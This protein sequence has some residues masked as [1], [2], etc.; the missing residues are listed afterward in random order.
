MSATLRQLSYFVA[1]AEERHFGRAAD[2]VHVTQPA[3]ST[4][5][6]TLEDRLGQPM[7]RLGLDRT[8]GRLEILATMTT[9]WR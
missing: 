6:R 5:I 4:Q 9:I 8:W 2:R 1:L 3:L 7:I